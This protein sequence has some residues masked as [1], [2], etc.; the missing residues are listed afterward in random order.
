VFFLLIAG[1]LALPYFMQKN[2]TY[3][4]TVTCSNRVNKTTALTSPMMAGRIG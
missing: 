3:A 2:I 4:I 1:V